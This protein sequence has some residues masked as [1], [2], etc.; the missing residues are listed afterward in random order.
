VST[1]L[2]P[3]RPRRLEEIKIHL[4]VETKIRWHNTVTQAR[5]KNHLDAEQLLSHMLDLFDAEQ[6]GVLSGT[7]ARALSS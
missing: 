7:I 2:T 5:V 6:R 1:P 4:G 3:P